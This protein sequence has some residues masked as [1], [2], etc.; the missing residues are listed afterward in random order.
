MTAPLK[1]VEADTAGVMP[2]IG[3]RAHTAARTLALAPSVQK[4]EALTAIAAAIRRQKPGILAANADDLAEAKRAGATAR[5]HAGSRCGRDDAGR[6][7][8][9]H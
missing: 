6:S 9:R 8:R 5:A 1:T 7:R 4:D 3:R 2:E